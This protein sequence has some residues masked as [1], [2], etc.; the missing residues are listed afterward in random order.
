MRLLGDVDG[1]G[2][3]EHRS[4]R[5]G[6]PR[7][8]RSPRRR[9]P[10]RRRAPRSEP[11]GS[12]PSRRA[13][14]AR[15][16]PTISFRQRHA[17]CAGVVGCAHVRVN[18]PSGISRNE[19]AASRPSRTRWTYCASG[20]SRSRSGRWR[21]YM[22]RLVTP[23]RLPRLL[24]V[25][26]E[27]RRDRLAGRH[28]GRADAGSDVLRPNAPVADRRDSRDV[29]EEALRVDRPAVPAREQRDEERLVRD[30]EPRRAVEDHAEKRRARAADAENEERRRHCAARRRRPRLAR[31]ARRR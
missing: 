21:M 18:V 5:R 30:R 1:P 10:G 22:R 29:V 28:P 11:R 12:G 16:R 2:V 26:L 27:D 20:K 23:A 14:R 8:R 6:S 31:R 7:T 25:R 19:S 17:N 15:A 13:G 9:P 24:R 3:R 4:A